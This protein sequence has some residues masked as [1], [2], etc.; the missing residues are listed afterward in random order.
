MIIDYYRPKTIE[1]TLDLIGREGVL[2]LPMGGGTAIDR[3]PSKLIAVVDLQELPLAE[4]RQRGNQLEVGATTRLQALMEYPGLPASLRQA[5]I[6]EVSYNLRQIAT[7]AGTLVAAS[8]RSPLATAMLALNAVLVLRS[9]SSP[10]EVNSSL[11]DLLPV[12]NEKLNKHLITNLIIPSNVTLEYDSVS[13][14]PA[15]LPIVCCAVA[16]WPSGRT[17]V[18]LGGYGPAPILA[19]DGPD[20]LG[21]EVAA[22][23]AYSQAGD[24]WASASYRQDAV[25]M[26]VKRCIS[27][28]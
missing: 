14:T 17:R 15:D 3:S 18:T 2:A 12:R 4:I 22:R 11:G 21:V 19:F 7:I 13:R 20:R 6:H 8:G 1:E 28:I 16:T 5:I 25:G 27:G 10:G 26:L 9:S 24:A 23:E